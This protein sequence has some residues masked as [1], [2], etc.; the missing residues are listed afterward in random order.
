MSTMELLQKKYDTIQTEEGT[1]YG[2]NDTHYEIE[3]QVITLQ[4]TY[5]QMC[6]ASVMYSCHYLCMTTKKCSRNY[7]LLATQKVYLSNLPT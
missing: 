6:E 3:I 5:I 1:M 7:G 4:I 2:S